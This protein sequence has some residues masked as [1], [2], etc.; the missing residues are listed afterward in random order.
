MSDELKK[1]K[2]TWSYSSDQVARH[3]SI[4]KNNYGRAEGEVN[5]IN[6]FVFNVNT[7]TVDFFDGGLSGLWESA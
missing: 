1:I 3:H 2:S 6:R 4:K 7:K 5:L